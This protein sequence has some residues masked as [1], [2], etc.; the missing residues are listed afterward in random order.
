MTVPTPVYTVEIWSGSTLRHRLGYTGSGWSTKSITSLKVK[1]GIT[2]A[3]GG[4]ELTVPDSTDLGAYG[5]YKD[6]LNYEDIYIWLGWEATG[7]S[8]LFKGKIDTIK[9]DWNRSV[10]G[11]RTFVGRD[12]GEA[13]FRILKRRAYTG[14]TRLTVINLKNNAGLDASDT[15][16]VSSNTIYPMVLENETCF[17]GIKEVSDFDNK[18]FYVGTNKYLYWFTRQTQTGSEIFTTGSNILSYKVV[19]DVMPDKNMIWVFGM[20]D[21]ANITGSDWPVN[22]DDWTESG[23]LTGS[24]TGHVVSGSGEA[25]I[26]VVI[27]TDGT[28]DVATGSAGIKTVF[29]SA[30]EADSFTITLKKTIPDSPVRCLS[31]D[32]LHFYYWNTS[33]PQKHFTFKVRLET[34]ASNYFESNLENSYSLTAKR[35]RTIGLGPSNE[36]VSS[37]GSEDT[38]TGS[39]KWERTGDPD[40]FDIN[41]ITLIGGF[42]QSAATN[43]G[44]KI[45]GLYIGTRFQAYTGSAAST[46]SYDKRPLVVVNNRLNST[47][48]CVNEGGT[49][50][51]KLK[52]PLTQITVTVSGSEGLQVGKRYSGSIPAEN[53]NGYY[54]LIDLEHR[55]NASEGFVSKMTLSDKKEIRTPIP[56]IDYPTMVAEEQK[57]LWDQI[58][59]ALGIPKP[60]PRYTIP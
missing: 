44:I 11:T 48:Y 14:S 38:D 58:L 8:A 29:T 40:W 49:L 59:D 52:D 60:G 31:G 57:S 33:N 22:H 50:L 34:D 15:E 10:G 21:P 28:L 55:F 51:A 47:E 41:Y 24:W 39:Y 23:S 3:I 20:R 53:I 4:F 12:Y 18:D 26:P 5:L 56:I 25:D 7:S 54:E 19:R 45:D 9:S 42:S 16:I 2:S 6:V 35:E 1:P 32:I 13:L 43:A 46:G 27:G 17:A 37:T 30:D 36:G